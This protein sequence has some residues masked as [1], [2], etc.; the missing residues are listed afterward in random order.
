MSDPEPQRD[1]SEGSRPAAHD[2]SFATFI[3]EVADEDLRSAIPAEERAAAEARDLP[4]VQEDDAG[5]I[6]LGRRVRDPRTIISFLVPLGILTLLVVALPGFRL[7]EL[8][9]LIAQANPFWLLAAFAIY[10]LGFPLRGYR[11]ALLIRGTGY[12]LSVKD[13]TEIIFLSWLVNCLVPAKLGDVYRA[14]L[15]RVNF[16]I[17]LSRSFGTVFIERVFDL[18]AIVVLGLLAGFWSFR[19]G[20]SPEVQTIFAIGIVVVIALIVALIL[21]RSFGRRILERLRMPQRVVELYT[22]FEEGIFSVDRRTLP[23]ILLVTGMIWMTEALRLFFVVQ[24]MGFPDVTLGIS[25]A[26]FVALIASLLTAVPL[27][28]AG[29][30]LVELGI[31]GVLTTVYNVPQTEALAIALVDRSISVLS[32]IVLGSI[33]YVVSPKTKARSAPTPRTG[34]A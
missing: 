11:W 22:L 5:A 32:V 25:G 27:T 15:V 10:Y 6:P 23:V 1:P 4:F 26:V 14:Y 30:G 9:A 18:I 34:A 21:V 8:P 31:V 24:A 16:G 20:L 2:P 7:E 12:P 29:I 13:S 33:V 28:P 17:S 19:T 3:H